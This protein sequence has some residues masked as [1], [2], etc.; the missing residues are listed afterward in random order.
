M[1]ILYIYIQFQYDVVVITHIFDNTKTILF[2][3]KNRIVQTM[4]IPRTIELFID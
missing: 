1:F 2:K 3:N 4:I